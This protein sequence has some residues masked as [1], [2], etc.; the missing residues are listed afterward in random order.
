MDAAQSARELNTSMGGQNNSD[1]ALE[2]LQNVKSSSSDPPQENYELYETLVVVGGFLRANLTASKDS[3]KPDDSV[4]A[5]TAKVRQ[6]NSLS[7]PW[8]T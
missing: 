5:E 1:A 4:T 7:A 2:V 8:L 3:F 6:I